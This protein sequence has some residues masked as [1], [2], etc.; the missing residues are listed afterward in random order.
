MAPSYTVIICI[1]NINFNVFRFLV[2]QRADSLGFVKGDFSSLP[3]FQTYIRRIGSAQPREGFVSE[4]VNDFHFMIVCI[5]NQYYVFLRNKMNS[6]WML[7]LGLVAD[8]VSVS[9]T[10]QIFRIVV[11]SDNIS[12][13]AEGSHIDCADRTRFRVSYVAF[14][15][16]IRN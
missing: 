16:I 1:A 5:G 10:M 7:K 2:V 11:G 9:E 3:I 14:N 6:K 4:R 15:V 12:G 8:A 13:L